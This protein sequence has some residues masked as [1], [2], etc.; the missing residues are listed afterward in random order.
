M[1]HQKAYRHLQGGLEV[2]TTGTEPVWLEIP[3]TSA[4]YSAVGQ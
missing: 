2:I 3:A 4:Q 1:T